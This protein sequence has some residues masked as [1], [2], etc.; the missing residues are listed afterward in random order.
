MFCCL[1]KIFLNE[2]DD[3]KPQNVI[4]KHEMPAGELRFHSLEQNKNIIVQRI[5][6]KA[7][8]TSE[9]K[10]LLSPA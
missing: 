4:I 7:V 9:L 6:G 8:G 5:K 3:V 1:S 10:M 2:R